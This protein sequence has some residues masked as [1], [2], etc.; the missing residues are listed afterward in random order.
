MSIYIFLQTFV[1]GMYGWMTLTVDEEQMDG[2]SGHG[3]ARGRAFGRV[4]GHQCTL[5]ED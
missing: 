2:G 5:T 3:A 4:E 1:D